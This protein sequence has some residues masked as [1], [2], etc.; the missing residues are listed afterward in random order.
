MSLSLVPITYA[1]CTLVAAT[2]KQLLSIGNS[3]PKIGEEVLI[4]HIFILAWLQKITYVEFCEIV[5]LTFLAVLP[6][7]EVWVELIRLFREISSSLCAS[8]VVDERE[9]ESPDD[10]VEAFFDPPNLSFHLDDFLSEG[11]MI[12]GI[13]WLAKEALLE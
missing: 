3:R 8:N 5:T 1:R 12:E 6:R 7:T 9:L 4:S 13:A 2:S 11:A 10:L